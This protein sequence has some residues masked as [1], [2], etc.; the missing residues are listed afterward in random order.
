MTISSRTGFNK[1][2]VLTLLVSLQLIPWAVTRAADTPELP[3]PRVGLEPGEVVEIVINALAENDHPFPDAGIAITFNFA[4]P[5]NK[6]HT[7]PLER[8][9][10]L[11]KGPVFGDMVNHRDST[12]SKI[13]VDG[14]KAVRVVRIVG[15]N[16][17]IFY[18]AFRLGLQ[19]DG[20]YAGMWLTEGVWPVEGPAREVLAL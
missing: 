10:G 12:L 7:G 19:L 9:S 1:A 13:V 17:E 3:Q 11:V 2:L 20:D 4:S 18:F 6:E 14:S 5:D 8:F 15:E 16:N